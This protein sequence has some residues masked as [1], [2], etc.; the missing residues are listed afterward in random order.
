MSLDFGF[1]QGSVSSVARDGLRL[2]VGSDGH[3][4]VGPGGPAPLGRALREVEAGRLGLAVH[5]PAE[6]GGGVGVGGEAIK[7]ESLANFCCVG[8]SYFYSV[9][10]N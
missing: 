6:G 7:V 8:S 4:D 10:S 1:S 3:G 5:L 9:R 2:V